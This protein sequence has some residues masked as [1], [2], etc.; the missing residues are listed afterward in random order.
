MIN[1]VLIRTRV[2]QVAYA[3]LHRGELK[4]TAAEQDLLLSL[5]RTYDLY[6]FL[7]QL[8]PSFTEFYREVLEIRKNKHLATKAERSPNLRLLENRLAA[9][10]AASEKLN[11]WY[12]GFS[13]RWE[14]DEAL[15][16][17]LLRRIEASDIYANY[18]KATEVGFEEDRAFWVDVF[19]QIITTDEMLAE[20]LEQH[21]IYWQDDLREVEKAE[22]EDRP[23]TED[24]ALQAALN[25]AREAGAY[26]S[27]RLENG[28]VE[29]VKDFVEKTL[30]K[31]EEDTAIDDDIRPA[32]KDEDDERFARLLFRQTLLKYDDQMKII[33]PVLSAGWS[34]E[35]LADVDALLLNLA[36]TEFLYFPLIPTQITIN[37]YVELAKHYSTNH[38]ASFVNGVLDALARKLKE[39]G[40][41]LK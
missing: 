23:A 5:H 18:L 33:E 28:P 25:E 32:F 14:E 21:S 16:R 7:L 10:L 13:L 37:E 36:V 4:L 27:A 39:E 22:V 19:T 38:S 9:K 6:L 1:R 24:E 31:S 34:S 41:I 15:L 11:T 20:W 30:R 17:H 12:E 40:K 2:L 8:I 26:Q 35:R 3:H 29:V